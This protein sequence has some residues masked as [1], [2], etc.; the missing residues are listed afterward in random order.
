MRNKQY[1]KPVV[2]KQIN[3]LKCQKHKKLISHPNNFYKVM[4]NKVNKTFD[5]QTVEIGIQKFKM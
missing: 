4:K 3:K 5:A 2:S 1:F